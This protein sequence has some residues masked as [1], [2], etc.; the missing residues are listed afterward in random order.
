MRRAILALGTLVASI[1]GTASAEVDPLVWS[2]PTQVPA[3][4]EQLTVDE[5]QARSKVLLAEVGD[6]SKLEQSTVPDH[7]LRVVRVDQDGP[8]KNWN[9]KPGDVL[10]KVDQHDVWGGWI[11][12][13]DSRRR[14][15]FFRHA[16]GRAQ[17]VNAD[18]GQ[19][20]IYIGSHWRPELAYLR[21][22]KL[23]QA[24]WDEF[25][26]VGCRSAESDPDLAETAWFNA[27]RAGYSQDEL[28]NICGAVIALKQGRSTVAADFAYLA[29]EA[30]PKQTKLVSP[31][32]LLRV[33]LANYKFD[34]A[35]ELCK[36]FPQQLAEEPR[37]FRALADLHRAR[38]E[39][40]RIKEAPSLLAEKRYRDDLLP[41]CIP[42]T[43]DASDFAPKLRERNGLTLLAPNGNH[44]PLAFLPPEHARD[45]EF[46]VKFTVLDL[47]AGSH[48]SSLQVAFVPHSPNDAGE[49]TRSE[50][51][52]LFG[53]T[54]FDGS[55][56]LLDHVP[57]V[58]AT[59]IDGPSLPLRLNRQY[60]VR[61]IHIAGQAEAFVDGQRV[62]YQP[63]IPN[64]LPLAALVRPAGMRVK[65][66][67]IEF[68]ELIE[69]R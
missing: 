16:D 17:M 58:N 5:Y 57:G 12:N 34:D 26:V 48:E 64:R 24:K 3:F 11:P 15:T 61:V 39:A 59:L 45:L 18:E 31:V 20:G 21:S 38:P 27:L 40:D 8:A 56:V 19:I 4:R 69:R 6:L 13:Q 41:S 49:L 44:F 23:R 2:K 54:C 63:V 1:Y 36:R 51:G 46:I 50:E 35:F 68:H 7:G 55:R 14:I 25:V 37:L 22:K 53:V 28:A 43:R 60:E 42:L 29:R 30:E 47:K 9:L 62:L 32:I 67:S 10:T 52:R 66:E 65:I 33:M